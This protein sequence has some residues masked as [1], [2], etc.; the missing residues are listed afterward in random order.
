MYL[1]KTGNIQY[2]TFK[3]ILNN[4]FTKYFLRQFASLYLIH[5]SQS[6]IL[7]SKRIKIILRVWLR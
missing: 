1:Y 5:K 2:N 7:I 6:L 3:S 4:Y